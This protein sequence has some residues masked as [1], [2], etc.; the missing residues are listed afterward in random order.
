MAASQLKL[1]HFVPYRLSVLTN[2]VSRALALGYAE[3]FGLTIAQ[4]RIVAVL[5]HESDLSAVEVAKR[6]VMD[7]VSVSRAVA[8]LESDGRLIRRVDSSDRRRSLLRLSAA[9]RAVY[10]EIVPLARSYEMQL[11]STLTARER[12]ALD[13]LLTRLTQQASVLDAPR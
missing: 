7:K 8:A 11:L 3:R 4:W 6:T 10:R 13:D 9:G 5:G 1:D 2:T 12:T